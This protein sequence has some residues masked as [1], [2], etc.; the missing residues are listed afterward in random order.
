MINNNDLAGCPLHSG[1]ISISLGQPTL[2]SE[3]LPWLVGNSAA[4][5]S[6]FKFWTKTMERSRT[7]KWLL[8]NTFP[9]ECHKVR[10]TTILNT[11]IDQSQD[12]P[13]ILPIG[14]LNTHVTIKN[15]SLWEEDS[16]CLDWLDKQVVN[17]VLYISFGSWV[18]PIGEAKVNDLAFA[19]ELLKRPFIWVLGPTWR[20]GLPKGYLERISKQGKIVSWAPQI[21]VLQHET[22][23]CYL[24]HCGWNS[25]VEAIQSKKRLL[26]YPIAGDQFVNCAYIVQKWRIGVR[27]DGFG[28]KDLEE[29]LKRIMEDDEM[30]ERIGRLNEMT[31]GKVVSSRAMANLTTFI[32]D[33]RI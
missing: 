12:C 2:S 17:S 28:L 22:V 31:M 13:Q 1:P 14:P 18:S 21:D 16:S 32:C 11:K 9:D 7:L 20:E 30:S 26:C 27:M 6:R 23:G 4:R 10:N 3:D 25:T 19:L 29:G 24:T 33:I 5:I 8:V 15:V